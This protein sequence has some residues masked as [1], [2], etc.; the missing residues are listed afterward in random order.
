MAAALALLDRDGRA[1]LTMRAVAREL[2]V[3]GASLYTHVRSKDDLVDGVLDLVLEEVVLPPTGTAWRAAL[4]DGFT[5]YRSTLLDHPAVVPLVT[6]RAHRSRAQARLVERSIVL[7]EQAG[8]STRDAVQAHVT[9]IAFTIGFVVQEVGRP[10]RPPSADEEV[11]PVLERAVA[12][13]AQVPVD[14]RFR[15]GLETV[16]LGAVDRPRGQ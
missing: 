7:L 13:L 14:D 3:E 8:L 16:I 4:V 9:L 12:A 6:E 15:S 2:D 1:A 11:G 5:A 10:V